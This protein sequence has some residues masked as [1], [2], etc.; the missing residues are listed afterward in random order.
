MDYPITV[1]EVY[2]R[3]EPPMAITLPAPCSPVD[4]SDYERELGLRIYLLLRGIKNYRRGEW[5]RSVLEER[6]LTLRATLGDT[7]RTAVMGGGAI[8]EL[9]YRFIDIAM[10]CLGFAKIGESEQLR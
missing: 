1:R 5:E 2:Q 7:P 4:I 9:A 10:V 6:Y 3:S 8:G